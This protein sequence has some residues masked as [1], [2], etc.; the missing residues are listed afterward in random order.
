[1]IKTVLA[2]SL[3][4][5]VAGC[6]FKGFKLPPDASLD[7]ELC[8]ENQIYPDINTPPS[9]SMEQ[10]DRMLK[11]ILAKMAKQDKDMHSCGGLRMGVAVNAFGFR[12]HADIFFRAVA[13]FYALFVADTVAVV[14]RAAGAEYIYP[15]AKP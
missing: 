15:M 9:A 11:Q 10:R 13:V 7:W 4:A 2:L 3:S 14:R 8:N 12:H 5:L 6:T 1:M